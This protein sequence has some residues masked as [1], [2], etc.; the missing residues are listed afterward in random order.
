MSRPDPF[1]TST[2]PV[3][4][5]PMGAVTVGDRL[6]MVRRFTREQCMQAQ[7]LPGLQ[8]SVQAAVARRLRQLTAWE[9]EQHSRV[10]GSGTG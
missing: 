1:M 7:A 2:N 3:T 4:G 8:A 5:T 9:N 10:R 6:A